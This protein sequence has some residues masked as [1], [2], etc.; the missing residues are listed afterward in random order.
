M[1]KLKKHWGIDSNLQ[2]LIIIFVFSI[3]GSS[4]VYLVKP[5]LEILG[6]SREHFGPSF[7]FGG[8]WYYIFRILFIFPIYQ[9]LL[10]FFGW[11]LGQFSFFWNFEKKM[12]RRLGLG[13][14][15][16]D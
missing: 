10:V 8:F 11:L 7:W 4:A 15:L 6:L 3:T 16:N 2:I 9:L 14:L 13:K 1:E 5:V 12:L